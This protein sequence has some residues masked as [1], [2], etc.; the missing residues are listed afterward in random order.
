[1]YM[2][3]FILDDPGKLNRVLDAWDKIGVTGATIIDST[4]RNRLRRAQQ[5]GAPFMAGINRLMASDI[6]NHYTLITIVP[7]EDLIQHCIQAVEAIVGDLN[8]PNTGVLAAWP[9]T[10]V[11]GVSP[12]IGKD[13]S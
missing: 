11:K 9:L 8:E 10:F 13:S 2:V 12:E 3:M 7:T 5:V 1:M 4:G 6:Q